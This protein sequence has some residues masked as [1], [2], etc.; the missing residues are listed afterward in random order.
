MNVQ[1][2]KSAVKKFLPLLQEGKSESELIEAIN[3]DEKA[4]TE[5]EAAKILDAVNNEFE[6]SGSGEEEEEG[7]KPVAGGKEYAHGVYQEWKGEFNAHGEFEPLK[8][9]RSNIKLHP[10]TAE[11]LNKGTNKNNPIKYLTAEEA[12]ALRD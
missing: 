4:Y 12:E 9:L 5:E 10:D 6:Q 1:R 3:S 8:K 2:L 11:E 7:V